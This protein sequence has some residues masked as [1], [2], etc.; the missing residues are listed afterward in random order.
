MIEHPARTSGEFRIFSVRDVRELQVIR[1]LVSLGFSLSEMKQVLGL[2]RNKSDACTAVS[3]LLRRKLV[4]VKG[5]IQVLRRL[6][7]ELRQQVPAHSHVRPAPPQRP[8][9]TE[10]GVGES[11]SDPGMRPPAS[12]KPR[13]WMA[14]LFYSRI[15]F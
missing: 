2:R 14:D 12:I 13:A 1:R 9:Q 5:K 3:E 7:Q 6:E 11:T 15:S 10:H 4:K 8:F